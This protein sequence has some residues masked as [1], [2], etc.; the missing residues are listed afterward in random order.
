MKMKLARIVTLVY[1]IFLSVAASAQCGT[2]DNYCQDGGSYTVCSGVVYDDGGG[3]AYDGDAFITFCPETAGLAISLDFQGFNLNENFNANNSDVLNVYDGPDLNAPLL[4]SFSGMQLQNVSIAGSVNNPSGCLTL[5]LLDRGTQNGTSNAPNPGFQAIISCVNPCANPTS[6]ISTIDPAIVTQGNSITGCIGEPLTFSS[7]GSSAQTGF[8]ISE[9][10]WSFGNDEIETGTSQQVQYTYDEPGLYFVSLSVIDNNDCISLENIPI[11]VLVSTNPLF[12]DIASINPSYCLGTDITLNAGIVEYPEW[13]SLPPL[14]FADTLPLPDGNG[15]TFVSNLEFDIFD[16]GTIID[17]CEDLVNIQTS[18]E[19][20]YAGDLDISITCPNGTS[21]EMLPFPN[22]MTNT[23][24]G[25]PVDDPS[26]PNIVGIQYEY[27]WTANPNDPVMGDI[28]TAGTPLPEGSYQSQGDLCALVGCPLNGIWTITITD[29]LAA[30]DGW[31]ASWTVN[32]APELYPGVVT[33]T[34]TYGGGADSS[35]WSGPN[36]TFLDAGADVIEL[37]LTEPGTYEYTYETSNNFGCTSDTTISITIQE[38]PTL[39]VGDDFAYQCQEVELT[40]TLNGQPQPSC[41]GASQVVTYCYPDNANYVETYCPDNPGD[42]ITFMSL[43]FIQGTLEIPFDDLIIYNGQNTSA[44]VLWNSEAVNPASLAGI[45]VTATNPSGCITIQL[46]SDGLFSCESGAEN[47]MEYEVS[48]T[49]DVEYIFE[50]SP[51]AGLS[52]PQGSAVTVEQINT[53]TT[54]NVIAYPADFPECVV[55]D[56]I[57]ISVAN[58]LQISLDDLAQDCPDSTLVL[59][60]PEIL[61]GTAPFI[62]IWTRPDGTTENTETLVVSASQ[63]SAEYCVTVTDVCNLTTEACVDVI[64]YAP[65]PASFQIDEGIGCAPHTVTMTSD[66][67]AYQNLESMRWFSGDGASTSVFGSYSFSYPNDGSFNPILELTDVN[68]CVYRD[69]LDQS[70]VVIPMPIADFIMTPEAPVLPETTVRFRDNSVNATSYQYNFSNLGSSLEPDAE[71]TF[72]DQ[73]GIYNIELIAFNELGCSDTIRKE[74]VIRDVINIFIPNSFTPDGD[75]LNDVWRVEGTGFVGQNFELV[76]LNR[77]G[78]PVFQST[79]PKVPWLGDMQGNGYY[80][81]DSLYF[82]ILK[83]QD[84]E[85]DVR[86]EYQG[87]IVLVR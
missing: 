37:N 50:W 21:V 57:T 5:E 68:G 59:E 52:A 32:F 49:S 22:G 69:T 42:G 33:F 36:I 2:P 23:F 19:H 47:E 77:W 41:S 67:T 13:T 39:F 70:I 64:P 18:L 6:F 54:F 51:S 58:D 30:D 27:Q 62:Y 38:P 43:N 48:C 25:E 55:F 60:A 29:N 87:H 17:D 44:P 82:Y 24:F 72:P 73:R 9:Y 26:T 83:V 4:G 10:I 79:D 15:F 7:N 76:I 1:L 20:S 12:N 40:A 45:E 65:I 3:E 63:G 16:E 84:I 8:V 86:Y 28:T 35:F 34:P 11:Q 53:T 61:V 74:L 46:T 85:N 31:L 71:F 14:I 81:Q 75:G 66:Y 56:D 78:Q 80:S